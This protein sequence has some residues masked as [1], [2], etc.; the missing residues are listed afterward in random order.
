[1]QTEKE[2]RKNIPFYIRNL[3]ENSLNFDRYIRYEV[4]DIHHWLIV[5]ERNCG[6]G[7][8][9]RENTSIMIHAKI[10]EQWVK[11]FIIRPHSHYGEAKC[12]WKV[13]VEGEVNNLKDRYRSCQNDP[14]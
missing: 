9:I 12:V 6:G 10:V 8:Q 4:S 14:S 13:H 7:T 1:M 3:N 11:I 5:E 2:K